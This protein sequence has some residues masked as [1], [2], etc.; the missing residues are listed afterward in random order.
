MAI[1]MHH[2]GRSVFPTYQ[3]PLPVNRIASSSARPQHTKLLLP[4]DEDFAFPLPLS[5]SAAAPF[6][7][8]VRV[9]QRARAQRRQEVR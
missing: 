9:V 1:A 8:P 2:D 4:K 7:H 3:R 5:A 6:W